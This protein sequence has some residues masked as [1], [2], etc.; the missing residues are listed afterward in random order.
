MTIIIHSQ[1]GCG[2]NAIVSGRAGFL[3]HLARGHTMKCPTQ[4]LA[5]SPRS[6]ALWI[7]ILIRFLPVS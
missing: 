1:R 3:P 4:M 2:I 7:Q 6:G 5:P